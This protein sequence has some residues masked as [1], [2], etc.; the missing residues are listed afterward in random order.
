MPET[1]V[2]F[3]AAAAVVA[4]CSYGRYIYKIRKS[5]TEPNLATWVIWSVVGPIIFASY[6]VTGAR[7]SAITTFVYALGPPIIL[8][9]MYRKGVVR[10]D[11]KDK[12]CLAASVFGFVLWIAFRNSMIALYINI[13]VDA[14]AAIPTL[15]DTWREPEKEDRL[16]WVLS[17]VASTTNLFAVEKWVAWEL[18]MHPSTWITKDFAVCI[19]PI[20]LVLM[21][22]SIT[23]LTFVRP[24]SRK[25]SFAAA[26]LTE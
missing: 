7:D 5:N 2:L 15:M 16:T 13:I 9:F 14:G 4:A 22:G 3:G 1:T 23:V 11:K 20:V 17:V 26:G 12:L 10:L 21:C 24:D 6:V 25:A 8:A 18:W 19:Y